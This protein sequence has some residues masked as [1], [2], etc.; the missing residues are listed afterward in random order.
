MNILDVMNDQEAFAPWFEGP[1]WDS[2]RVI[3]RAAYA[4]P[5][6]P[7]ELEVFAELAGWASAAEASCPSVVRGRWSAGRE[8]QHREP[9]GRLRGDA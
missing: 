7:Q 3:L 5:M 6:S 1:S 9:A 8:G 4:L 2:W